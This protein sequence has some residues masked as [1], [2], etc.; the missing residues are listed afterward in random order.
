MTGRSPTAAVAVA[1]AVAGVASVAAALGS[2]I[3]GAA[4][5][6]EPAERVPLQRADDPGDVPLPSE[7]R[8]VDTSNPDRVIGTGTPASCTSR[9]VVDAVAAGGIITFDCGPDPV[10]ITMTQTAKVV[11]TSPIVVLDGGGIVTLSGAGQRRI[12]YMNTCDRAQIWTTPHCQNQD[13]PQLTMQGL[14]FR[15]GNSTGDVT[16]GGG[17]GA[18]FVRGGR[19]KV[20][21]S[22]FIDNRCD[23]AGPDLGG[24]ALR[25]LSQYEGLPVVVAGSE[26]RGN[27]C[28][29][30]AAISSIGVS[31]R[32]YNSEFTNNHAI[33]NGANP[34]RAG[35][36][37]GGS[38]GAIYLD[39]NRFTLDLRGSVI[40]G[41][42]AREGGGAIFFVS[43]N[44]TGELRIER[45]LLD[46]NPSLG[47]ETR[48][49]PGIFFL[50]RGAPQVVDSTIR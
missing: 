29:N 3:D 15:D 4:T 14:T 12:L 50:G 32:I 44:R 24:A 45:S 27:D 10:T 40:E 19:V 33:G 41:N 22:T 17:G 31:W 37:G 23:S 26:F 49:F 25:V 18:V 11:N 43:N 42:S 9:A 16:E 34:A 7:A 47:F 38:G 2:G 30:G 13:H 28:S 20:L 48:G 35:T 8:L 21:D 36:P 39:G 5:A 6:D 46:G 1:L